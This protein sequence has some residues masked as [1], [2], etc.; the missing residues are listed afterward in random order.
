MPSKEFFVPLKLKNPK[1]SG[2]RIRSNVMKNSLKLKIFS[3]K[4]RTSDGR[5][6]VLLLSIKRNGN[7]EISD[8]DLK[9]KIPEGI[10][11]FREGIVKDGK[12]SFWYTVDANVRRLLEFKNRK[13]KL[14][15]FYQFSNREN[16]IEMRPFF[17]KP[18]G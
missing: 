1:S 3:K 8:F 2:V 12:K 16:H 10:I 11:S 18:N 4:V 5:R 15:G 7:L 6:P 14:R 17:K 13:G 9:S